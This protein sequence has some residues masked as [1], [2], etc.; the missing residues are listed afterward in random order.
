[1][2]AL[3]TIQEVLSNA[4]IAYRPG[5]W[6]RL[7]GAD[8]DAI[9]V[10][11]VSG[12]WKD[13]RTGEHGPW[14]MLCAKLGI[15][16][17]ITI[18]AQA[19]QQSKANQDKEDEQSR[20]W[21]KTQWSRGIPAVQQKRPSGWAQASWDADQSVYADH[22]EAVYDYLLSRGLE[23]IPL[24][25]MIRIA[26]A[27]SDKGVDA[28]MQKCGADFAFLIPMYSI[29]KAE[30]P[31][32]ISGVQRTYLKFAE[33]KYSSVQKVGRAMLGKKGVTTLA[34]TGLPVILPV[35]GPVLGSGEGFETVASWV[36]TMHR[37]GVVCWDWS[38]L[39][40]WSESLQ[41]G[42]NA[43][44][45]AFLVDSDKSETGQRESAAAARRVLSHEHGKAVYLLPPESI[46]PDSK[47]NRDW[48]D[49][50]K[51]APDDQ[52]AAEIIHA[53]H[54]SDEN[55]ALAPISEDAPAIQQ[56]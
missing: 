56:Q 43:P 5:R 25:P 54:K 4:G 6:L 18:D 3:T 32:N 41:P 23:P 40:A 28:E 34:A 7:K 26:P 49:L 53:W 33:D 30:I 55:L 10:N 21:A 22:R 44:L 37:P 31:E 52:F 8:L 35:S 13:H 17:G 20:Q 38:G 2:N 50:L 16:G 42:E 14:P 51:Q 9:S 48:N 12:G 39:K 29:G 15:S 47:G 36:Q 45:V 11:S 19:I 1:M 24:M 46:T 27:L